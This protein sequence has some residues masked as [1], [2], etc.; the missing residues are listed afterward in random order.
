MEV[1][2]VRTTD[3]RIRY[4]LAGED[5]FPVEPVRKYLRFKDNVGYARNT[6]RM[7]C[8]HLKLYFTYLSERGK[9]YKRISID[10]IAGFAGWL[11]NPHARNKKVVPIRFEPE[12]VPQTVNK[13]VDAVISFYDYLVRHD[14]YENDLPEKLV[15]F[16]RTPGRN[17]RG[18]LAGIAENRAVRSHILKL[19]EPQ[20]QVK[21]ITKESVVEL[22]RATTNLRDY[23]LLYLLF[24]TGF[25]IGEA[26]SL[27]LE[28]F[29]ISE[30]KIQLK[31]RGELENQAEIKSVA[32]P[33][34][35]DIT[36]D[37]ADL[38][39]K[40][41]CTYHACDTKT[42]HVFIKI[43]GAEAGKAMTYANV[44]NV[45]RT[46]R[47]KTGIAVTPHVFRHTSLSLLH[48]AGWLAELLR[49]RA[50]HKNIYTTINTYVHPS[51]EE[52][53]EVFHKTASTL[54]APYVCISDDQGDWG[55]RGDE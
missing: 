42:N 35:L 24:E 21:V 12:R 20:R 39:M 30:N 51:D 49:K 27:W 43:G 4:Y 17:Y 32:S 9:D 48:S 44:D 45:F 28:D 15:K 50:G 36:Q 1:M 18:F 13:A 16:I 5:G 22:L 19:I 31:D 11:R 6:L 41:V 2:R 33:R 37:L 23:F 52:M 53:A 7:H 14:E 55:V 46:L 54:K 3:G 38:F 25:R 47:D 40:Y 8:V 26:L 10:D 34:I 29:D